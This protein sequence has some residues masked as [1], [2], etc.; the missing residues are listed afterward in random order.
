MQDQ[1]LKVSGQPRPSKQVVADHRGEAQ[2]QHAAVV[3]SEQA[4]AL[5]HDYVQAV[6]R[7][8]QHLGVLAGQ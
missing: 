4:M 8:A 3:M 6:V 1:P 5:H 7:V 2:P